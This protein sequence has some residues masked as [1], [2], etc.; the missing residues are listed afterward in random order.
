MMEVMAVQVIA[1]SFVR[2]MTMIATGPRIDPHKLYTKEELEV[3]LPASLL[4]LIMP[5]AATIDG[6]FFGQQLDDL[7]LAVFGEASSQDR[8]MFSSTSDTNK[9]Y[10]TIAQVAEIL[11]SS[12]R[13]VTRLVDSGK[14]RALDLN[15]GMGKKKRQLRFRPE[16]IEDLEARMAVQPEEQPKPK[17]RLPATHSNQKK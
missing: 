9:T 3:L 17:F 10:L 1:P 15:E 16:W 12:P 7:I 14:L 4:R 2:Y 8:R 13:E 6:L 5:K 11:K